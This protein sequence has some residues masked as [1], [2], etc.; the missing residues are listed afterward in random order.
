MRA[1]R[2]SK[3][4]AI[5]DCCVLAVVGQQMCSRKGVA[6]T[7]FAALAKA[8]INIR[9]APST[10]ILL[11]DAARCTMTAAHPTPCCLTAAWCCLAVA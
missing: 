7:V 9:F 8:N 5:D 3:V 2:I 4:E 1:G 10:W 6:A 11:A